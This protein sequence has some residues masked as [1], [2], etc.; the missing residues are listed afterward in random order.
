MIDIKLFEE[1]ILEA[2]G[3][4][5]DLAHADSYQGNI[6]QILEEN[7]IPMP[8]A[9]TVYGGA[10]P[11][12]QVNQ[13]DVKSKVKVNFSI[14]VIGLHLGSS[15]EASSDVRAILKKVREKLNGLRYEKRVLLWVGESL[16]IILDTGVCAYE[17]TYEYMDYLVQ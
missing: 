7:I 4:I 6:E 9:L 12:A 17:Q 14:F 2:L 3:E 5:A 1:K 15:S 16:E 13:N 11:E 10:S 8:A